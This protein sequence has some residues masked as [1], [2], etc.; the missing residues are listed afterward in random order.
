[1]GFEISTTYILTL[2]ELLGF[3]TSEA[4]KHS[5]SFIPQ[6]PFML[7][8]VFELKGLSELLY[9]MFGPL[10]TDMSSLQGY[11]AI[12]G[13]GGLKYYGTCKKKKDSLETPL[14]NPSRWNGHGMPVT[15]VKWSAVLQG[16]G[17]VHSSPWNSEA[18]R[19]IFAVT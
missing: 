8:L 1:M 4:R 10:Q 6:S 15:F 18:S 19:F 14:N 2:S 3:I 16:E 9:C 13:P 5:L 7:S 17:G 11:A 12:K